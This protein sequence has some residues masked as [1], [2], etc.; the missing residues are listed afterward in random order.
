MVRF[1]STTL[2]VGVG[3]NVGSLTLPLTYSMESDGQQETAPAAGKDLAK[4]QCAPCG[5][6]Y[7]PAVGDPDRGIRPGTAFEDLP[8]DWTCPV[9]GVPK[10]LFHRL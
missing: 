4:Y 9:C 1:P 2:I 6:I 8:D 5:H 7:D 10:D 3:T